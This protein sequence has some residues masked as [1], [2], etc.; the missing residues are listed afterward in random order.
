MVGCAATEGV[1]YRTWGK[2]ESSCRRVYRVVIGVYLYS[3]S[4][5]I[6]EK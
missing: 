4:A 2:V 6:V 1:F 3:S 5:C